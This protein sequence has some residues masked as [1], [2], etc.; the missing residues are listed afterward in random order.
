[1]WLHFAWVCRW[2]IR[3]YQF[4]FI[5]SI[6]ILLMLPPFYLHNHLVRCS[7]C[8]KIFHLLRWLKWYLKPGISTWTPK[9][10]MMN[11]EWLLKPHQNTIYF[12]S[13]ILVKENDHYK[14]LLFPERMMLSLFLFSLVVSSLVE[15]V[16][17]LKS[18]CSTVIQLLSSSPSSAFASFICHVC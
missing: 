18:C 17:Y 3:M 1:M 12:L 9:W 13:S 16:I 5:Y 15:E 14:C 4:V 2:D 7:C 8:P 10:T 6:H 11:Y